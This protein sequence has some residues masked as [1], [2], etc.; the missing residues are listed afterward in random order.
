[1]I[2]K[3]VFIGCGSSGRGLL[4]LW[5]TIPNQLK[6]YKIIIVEPKE[7]PDELLD[8]YDDIEHLKG[9]IT[10][11]NMNKFFDE[12]ID[13]N[14]ERVRGGGHAAAAGFEITLDKLMAWIGNTKLQSA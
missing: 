8:R 5:Q 12:Y 1:M 2:N 4:E 14:N 9:K 3:F 10:K 13:E 7:I 11:E 6:N